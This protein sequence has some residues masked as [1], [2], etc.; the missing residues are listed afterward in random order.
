MCVCVCV[1]VLSLCYASELS[2][3]DLM[4][5]SKYASGVMKCVGCLGSTTRKLWLFHYFI[6]GLGQTLSYTIQLSHVCYE[7]LTVEL[8][9]D[10]FFIMLFSIVYVSATKTNAFVGKNRTCHSTEHRRHAMSRV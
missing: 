5:H 6:R 8:R 3:L 1:Y 9:V 10:F 4:F 7:L 2:Q